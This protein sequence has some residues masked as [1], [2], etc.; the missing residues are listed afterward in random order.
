MHSHTRVRR[1]FFQILQACRDNGIRAVVY[2]STYNVVFCGQASAD[3][4]TA[5]ACA[6]A[7]QGKQPKRGSCWVHRWPDH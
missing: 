4:A 6:H 5:H 7:S 3:G 2:V 1:P